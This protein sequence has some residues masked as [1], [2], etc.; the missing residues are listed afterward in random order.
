[1][2]AK[3]HAHTFMPLPHTV[4]ANEPVKEINEKTRKIISELSS[5]GMAYGEWKKQEKI[6]K[7][8]ANYLKSKKLSD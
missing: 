1:M 2:G 3:I 6:A 4:F 5:K 7:N 8:I